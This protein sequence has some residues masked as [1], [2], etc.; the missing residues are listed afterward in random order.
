MK[1]V[2][3]ITDN[4]VSQGP[5]QIVSEKPGNIVSEHSDKED[6]GS[7]IKEA[8]GCDAVISQQKQEKEQKF[9]RRK[10]QE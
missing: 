7:D 10:K 6:K 9:R 8:C 1:Q 2:R 5:E 4:I 3:I